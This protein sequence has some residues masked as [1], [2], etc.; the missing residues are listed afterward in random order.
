MWWLLI[1]GAALYL[2]SKGQLT[3]AIQS[4]LP[5]ASLLVQ[6]VTG[7]PVA[8]NNQTAAAVQATGTVVPLASAQNLPVPAGYSKAK[9]YFQF[10]SKGN[11]VAIW[12]WNGSAWFN[13]TTGVTAH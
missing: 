10:D 12:S 11:I 8:V 9:P 6:D 7:S 1:G 5:V 4:E 3:Q 13:L 2:Y